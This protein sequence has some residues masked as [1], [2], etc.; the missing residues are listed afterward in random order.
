MV[1][2]VDVQ[3]LLAAA[4]ADVVGVLREVGVGA[5]RGEETGLAPGPAERGRAH[6]VVVRWGPAVLVGVEE[7]VGVVYL[8]DARGFPVDVW[9]YQRLFSHKGEKEGL[10]EEKNNPPFH[11]NTDSETL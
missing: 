6:V 3:S 8:E 4:D 11:T 10:G 1:A 7:V 5:F 2:V 9:Y